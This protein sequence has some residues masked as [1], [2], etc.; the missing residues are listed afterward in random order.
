MSDLR[1]LMPGYV[2]ENMAVLP[3]DEDP[4]TGYGAGDRVVVADDHEIFPGEEGIV[5]AIGRTS[6]GLMVDVAIDGI[7]DDAPRFRAEDL[8]KHSEI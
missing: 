1:N 2:A 4:Q 3:D 8:E 6:E 7:V 5:Q